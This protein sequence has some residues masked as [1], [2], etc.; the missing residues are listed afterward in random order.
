MGVCVFCTKPMPDGL[1]I[2]VECQNECDSRADAGRCIGCGDE[3]AGKSDGY[4]CGTC[5]AAGPDYF[6]GYPGGVA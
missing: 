6:R 5:K 3:P 2:H 1:R 4:K